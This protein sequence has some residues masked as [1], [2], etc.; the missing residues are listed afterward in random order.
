MSERVD[1]IMALHAEIASRL[2]RVRKTRNLAVALEPEAAEAEGQLIALLDDDRGLDLI[3]LHLLGWLYWYRCH[4]VPQGDEQTLQTAIS[5]LT[6][7]FVEDFGSFPEPLVPTLAEHA[8]PTALLL[9]EQVNLSP[10]LPLLTVAMTV[11]QRI[12]AALPPE[13]LNRD[14]PLASLGTILLIR[15]T[16]TDAMPDLEQAIDLLRQAMAIATGNGIKRPSDI[17]NLAAALQTRYERI[18][19]I[20]DLDE[21][22][23]L[24]REAVT[25][26]PPNDSGRL[27]YL[28]RTWVTHCG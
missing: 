15:F 14:I 7:C 22:I 26:A 20:A 4:A 1:K 16:L 19:T 3:S 28:Y 27:S 10:S 17:A 12:A 5:M 25:A 23:D 8:I 9:T 11:W 2:D 21:A 18:R 6:A 24:S 13:S